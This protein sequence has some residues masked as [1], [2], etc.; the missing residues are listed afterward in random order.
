MINIVHPKTLTSMQESLLQQRISTPSAAVFSATKKSCLVSKANVPGHH[1]QHPL[2]GMCLVGPEKE[3]T[4]KDKLLSQEVTAPT[5]W[6]YNVF[7]KRM[8][9]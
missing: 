2:V 9:Y 6:I 3:P 7:S 1:S 5:M 4:G 8:S